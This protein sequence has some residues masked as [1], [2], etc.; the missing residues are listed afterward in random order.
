LEGTLVEKVEQLRTSDWGGST[1]I[2]AAFTKILDYA[3]SVGMPQEQM[4]EVLLVLSDMQFD[5]A[6]TN[7]S[8]WEKRRMPRSP[9]NIKRMRASQAKAAPIYERAKSAFNEAGYALPRIV[10]WN[11]NGEYRSVPVSG[12]ESNVVMVSGFSPSLLK[13]VLA[14]EDISPWKAMLDTVDSPRYSRIS[15]A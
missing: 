12:T 13:S 14:G 2:D 4:P 9:K 1:N 6:T 7:H 8:E 5:I 11:L 3:K 10:F 15:L